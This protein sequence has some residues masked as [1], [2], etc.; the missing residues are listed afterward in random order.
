MEDANEYV[1]P[2][3]W[4]QE[5]SPSYGQRFGF[6]GGGGVPHAQFQGESSV[7]GG[8]IN[9]LPSY[10]QKYNIYVNR[11]AP[12]TIDMAFEANSAG[13]L[14]I[15]ADVTMTQDFEGNNTKIEY[16]VTDKYSDMVYVNVVYFE[17]ESF[18]LTT[19][20]ETQQF[21]HE[22]TG[23]NDFDVQNIR[24]AVLIQDF[25]GSKTIHQAAVSGY[26]GMYS[27]FSADITSGP[28][29]LN[30]N[31]TN[32]SLPADGI[33]SYSWD[34]DN[35]G[36]ED[37]NEENPSWSFT[38]EGSYSV[39]LT[40]SSDGESLSAV[41]ENYI[42]V[43]NTENISGN[44]SG[45]WTPEYG[46][47]HI[48][49]DISVQAGNVLIIDEGTVLDIAPGKKIE[50]LG[51]L[52]INGS[53]DANVI[54]SSDQTWSGIKIMSSASQNVVKY[55]VIENVAGAAAINASGS[56]LIIRNCQI[57]NNNSGGKAPL[58]MS[59]C[60]DLVIE[61][62]FIGF[63]SSNICGGIRISG[64]EALVKNN[65]IV[66]NSGNNG[67]ALFVKGGAEVDFINNTVSG[68]S[69]S[70]GNFG[71]ITVLSSELDIVNSIIR[72]EGNKIIEIADAVISVSYSD[73]ED[74]YEGTGNIDADP[75]FIASDNWF[76][77]PNS[78]CVDAGNPD[79]AYN[80][81]ESEEN[82]GQPVFPGQ[83]TLRADIGVTVFNTDYQTGNED[84]EQN[85]PFETSSVSAYP[86]PFNPTTSIKLTLSKE[87][88]RNPV[89]VVVY[90]VKGQ[91]VKTLINRETVKNNHTV[92]WNGQDSDNSSV[93]SGVY[94]V[95][96]FTS[97]NVATSKIIL[98]K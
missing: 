24:A 56:N 11:D 59:D 89:T 67:G 10:Q 21:V 45:V 51:R 74:G 88:E 8:G 37:S 57:V 47:Y 98:M 16:L 48:E 27:N 9:M 95:R 90:N 36:I 55:A 65:I 66:N 50:V 17:K 35:D 75:M 30:V 1:V 85:I 54:F 38:E 28:G 41:K 71:Q 29:V 63:N 70:V 12:C 33:D 69:Y 26:T 58:D 79:P 53:S 5:T 40:V 32:G 61:E 72:G 14:V 34:F 82:P 15:T 83:G 6:Y 2:L 22:V 81:T 52:A 86:N 76:V 84:Y 19:A 43:T 78:P 73:V 13:N 93:S 49:D 77:Q 62:N 4:K 25:G 23:L 91:A 3:I 31:F 68:N 18:N 46:I 44:V 92:D 94:F 87:E 7:V 39:R 97:K 80:D 20:G 60:N 96:M 42:T 64:E